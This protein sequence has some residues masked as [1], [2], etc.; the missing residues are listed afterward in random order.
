VLSLHTWYLL[1]LC[2]QLDIILLLGDPLLFLYR[3]P[4]LR[5]S[6]ILVP[7][8][9]LL[10]APLNFL[11]A[12]LAQLL[13]KSIIFLLLLLTGPLLYLPQLILHHLRVPFTLRA[14]NQSS[15]LI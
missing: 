13:D 5:L 9:S 8:F 4:L 11:A 6:L 7:C 15:L 14:V 3:L 12:P 1:L 10:Q 2:L